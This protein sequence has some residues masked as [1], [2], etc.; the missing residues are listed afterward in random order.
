MDTGNYPSTRFATPIGGLTN[1][2]QY[3]IK[4]IDADNISLSATDGGNAINFTTVGGGVSH[5]L[6]C[7]VD[8]KNDTFKLRID[9][10]D[11]NTKIGKTA[12]ASQLL[13]SLI[14][15]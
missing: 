15:I 7:K 6:N 4:Y 13:L 11:L 10:I 14:H 2:N 1:G 3:Y 9:N 8:G 12:S 5:S